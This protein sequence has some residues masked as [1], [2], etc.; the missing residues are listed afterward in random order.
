MDTSSGVQIGHNPEFQEE[1]FV[2]YLEIDVSTQQRLHS[3]GHVYQ[4]NDTSVHT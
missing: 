4:K 3:C 1:S 2:G